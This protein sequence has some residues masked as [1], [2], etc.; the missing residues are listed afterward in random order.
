MKELESDLNIEFSEVP[1]I[2]E[3]RFSVNLK[4]KFEHQQNLEE[5]RNIDHLS[6]LNFKE[7]NKIDSEEVI[8]MI[9]D[10]V[11]HN[12][13]FF[14]NFQEKVPQNE[15]LVT[16]K[17]YGE[18]P[19]LSNDMN[20]ERFILSFFRNMEVELPK[21]EEVHCMEW[22]VSYKFKV[23]KEFASL[24]EEN[25]NI[26]EDRGFTLTKFNEYRSRNSYSS[27]YDNNN[28]SNDN[29]LF[30]KPSQIIDHF[31]LKRP[32]QLRRIATDMRNRLS[33]SRATPNVR[34]LRTH[35][36]NKRLS[37]MLTTLGGIMWWRQNK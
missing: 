16:F 17:I 19:G 3:Y 6:K 28:W 22:N 2:D 15:N 18:F 35:I 31:P 33:M 10:T 4:K 36:Q 24:F 27:R 12:Q 21:I 23:D 14:N 26:F 9:M 8:D 5:N 37:L 11:F 25:A 34:Y 30:F 13:R 32:F 20:F 29:E 7:L 1:E